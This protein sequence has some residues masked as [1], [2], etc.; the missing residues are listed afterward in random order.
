MPSKDVVSCLEG[1]LALLKSRAQDGLNAK[2]AD[3]VFFPVSGVF[4]YRQTLP[5]RAQE[6]A[7]QCLSFLLQTGWSTISDADVA[8][9]LMV[10]L[11]YL[12][13]CE[14]QQ[15]SKVVTSAEMRQSSL[16]CLVAL[17]AAIKATPDVRERLNHDSNVPAVGHAVTVMLDALKEGNE[18]D[19]QF[20]AAQCLQLFASRIAS[21][22]LLR[23]FFPG[24]ASSLVHVMTAEGPSRPS[25]KVL[26]IGFQILRQLIETVFSDTRQNLTQPTPQAEASHRSNDWMKTAASQTEVV[27][28]NVSKLRSH[29]R[30]EVRQELNELCWTIL[31]ECVT[32]LTNALPVALDVIACSL[33]HEEN[34]TDISRFEGLLIAE[35]AIAEAARNLLYEWV[36]TTARAISSGDEDGRIMIITK[37]RVMRSLLE[38]TDINLELV[39][40]LLSSQLVAGLCNLQSCA[41][42]NRSVELSPRPPSVGPSPLR[43][44]ELQMSTETGTVIPKALSS[45]TFRGIEALVEQVGSTRGGSRLAR[46]YLHQAQSS[47]ESHQ[48]VCFW[49]CTC[50]IRNRLS[51]DRV[52]DAFLDMDIDNSTIDTGILE[53]ELYNLALSMFDI[54]DGD[55]R[56]MNELRVLALDAVT[57]RAGHAKE[58]FR[59]ELVDVLYPVVHLMGSP[60]A[61]VQ[62]HAISTLDSIA[63]ASGYTDTQQMLVDNVDYLVNAV[64]LK[65]NSYDISPQVPQVLIMMTKLCGSKLVPHLDDLLDS[66]FEALEHFHGYGKLVEL[67]FSMLNAVVEAGVQSSPF[68]IEAPEDVKHRNRHL[69]IASMADVVLETR[70]ARRTQ[71][72]ILEEGMTPQDGNPPESTPRQPWKA[73]RPSS[74]G[75]FDKLMEERATD[76]QEQ[77]EAASEDNG[78][79]KASGKPREMPLTK[80]H[81]MV[82]RIAELTQYHL[83]SPSPTIRALLLSLLVKAVPYLSRHEDTFLPLV[84]LLWPMLVARFA[85]TEAFVVSGVLEAM[86]CICEGAGDFMTT[87]IEGLWPTIEQ[88]WRGI[89]HASRRTEAPARSTHTHASHRLAGNAARIQVP[90]P[91]SSADPG[92]PISQA[93]APAEH[94]PRN[95]GT[96]LTSDGTRYIP[97]TALTVRSALTRFLISVLCH[98]R[99]S[100]SIFEVMLHEM[101]Y[102]QLTKE[103]R[104]DVRDALSQ[105][106][107]DAVW[108]AQ[109]RWRWS[110]GQQGAGLEDAWACLQPSAVDAKRFAMAGIDEA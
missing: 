90:G 57:L 104:D 7:L 69:T 12:A 9:Q 96:S 73:L 92:R 33:A 110:Q 47:G 21:P 66:T 15:P 87:R 20:S 5:V 101:L 63:M 91:L 36:G 51:A 22:E 83:P 34:N 74:T 77:P 95:A 55:E 24:I 46:Q 40:D 44:H 35:A 27:V 49:L 100:E 76:G 1:L 109:Q 65:L 16:A 60:N 3:Y 94:S 86:S 17:F 8:L 72:L 48:S 102:D 78:A 97:T 45:R 88:I 67:L 42:K 71:D 32:T 62:R 89:D 61:F 31:A 43:P 10:L 98:V 11:T 70:K 28:A 13:D 106:N 30:P 84:H 105:L 50:M 23:N 93:S 103:G 108:L 6:L 82:L 54:S 4:R 79:L 41:P 14:S 25:F 99:V 81:Q 56:T 58:G 29:A 68:A 80:T 38:D 39:D 59:L 107:P 64:G 18:L 53:Q 2:L 26:K 37:I 19:L 75:A 52:G 85:D